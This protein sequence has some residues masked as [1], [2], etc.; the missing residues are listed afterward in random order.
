MKKAVFLTALGLILVIGLLAGIK[1]WQIRTM[2]AQGEQFVPPP[3]VVTSAPVTAATWETLLMAVGSLEAVQGVTVTAEVDRQSGGHCFY[4]R[5][6]SL[7]QAT[8][9]F[10]R[11][12][13]S[14]RPS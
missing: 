11:T 8:C 12:S 4:S 3:E 5:F 2:I 9:W 13:P 1:I 6:N 10:S 7:Q 14:K